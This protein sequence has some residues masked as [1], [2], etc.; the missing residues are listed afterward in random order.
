MMLKV[1]SNGLRD[2]TCGT[3]HTM[4]RG[5]DLYGDMTKPCFNL[6]KK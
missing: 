4:L 5:E 1:H 6:L 2:E 3:P